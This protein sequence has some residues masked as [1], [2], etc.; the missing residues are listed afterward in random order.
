MTQHVEETPDAT[1]RHWLYGANL[2]VLVAV[3]V[4]I[5]ALALF[6]SAK[7]TKHWDI[8]SGGIYS[9]S[10]STKKLLAEIDQGKNQ[11]ELVNLFQSTG[12]PQSAEHERRVDD[13]VNDYARRSKNITVDDDAALSRD[14]LS[15][16]IMARYTSELKP[17]QDAIDDYAKV[18][19]DIGNLAKDEAP[20]MSALAQQPG[21]NQ[22]AVQ[23]ATELYSAMSAEIPD[24]LTKMDKLVKRETDSTTP[25][26]GQLVTTLKD[27]LGQIQSTLNVLATPAQTKQ[28][29][30]PAIAD[31][32]AKAAGKYKAVADELSAYIDR[33]NKLKP[34]TVEDIL[35]SIRPNTLVVLGPTS[36]KVISEY[37][38]F[39]QAPADP[40]NPQASTAEDFE[41][42]QAVSSA[43]VSMVR[44]EKVKV[45]LVTST[46]R[47]VTTSGDPDSWTELSN[48]L[49]DLNFDVMEW[50][51]PG[52]P[53]SPDQPPPS[54]TPPA[55]GKGVVWIVFPPSPPSAQ[56]M[57]SGAMP[58]P[59]PLVDAVHAHIAAG[60]NAL[61]LAD[62][63][64]GNPLMGM[65]PGGDSYPFDD[66][67]KSFGILVQPKYMAVWNYSA[68]GQ[69]EVIPVVPITQYEKHEITK[70]LAGLQTVFEALQSQTGGMEGAPTSVTVDS[71][72]PKGVDVHE[73][74]ETPNDADHWGET[75]YAATATFDKGTDMVP[76]IG[77][78]AASVKNAGDKDKEQRL[79]VIGSSTIGSD[80][81]VNRTSLA[82]VGNEVVPYYLYP[83]N[84]EL[85]DNSVLWLAGYENMI[86]V[87]AKSG[88]AMRIGQIS[89]GLMTFMHWVIYLW[90]PVLALIAG[91]VVWA[92][93]RR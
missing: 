26:W 78:A 50:S 58:D 10:D 67:A 89:P 76:P 42:E 87:S 49:K 36:A 29:F 46:P 82:Q 33:L 66:I 70:P 16:K 52:P 45:V 41:G 63:T 15:Q 11:Y 57:M 84:A 68:E 2:A 54:P 3:G 25:D 69:S 80:R 28:A 65:S 17:Y 90:I 73:L 19:K 83:G 39:K 88:V 91:G 6:V 20:N 93:R 47:N 13:L 4:T 53:T 59:K 8:T 62:A 12:D 72:V 21:L 85:V 37:D 7:Y 77:L 1:S 32:F 40:Q 27:P 38:I 64:G 55:Q 75:S 18:S 60:G 43:L 61:L 79:V 56:Q 35:S 34:L 51:P 5:V 48:R 86:A 9:L 74:I 44:P 92:V 30:P 71:T 81:L 24:A 23:V 31:Y 14:A 22:Q